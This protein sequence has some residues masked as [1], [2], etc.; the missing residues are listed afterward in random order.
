MAVLMIRQL[1]DPVL[2]KV[3]KPITSITDREQKLL[4][5][6]IDTLYADPGRAGLAAPQVGFLKRIAILD[7]GDGLVELLNPEIISRTGETFEYEACLSLPGMYGAVKRAESIVVKT[8]NRLG[9][10]VIIEAS[11]HKAR[12]IQHEMDHLDGVLYID[13]VKNGH[14]F[15]E[16]TKKPVD[17]YQMIQLSKQNAL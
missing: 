17:V 12:C 16:K 10:E 13:H 4:Q 15:Q 8:L 7:C 1:G 5:N 2:R 3:C 11:G 14:L 6:L 9:E